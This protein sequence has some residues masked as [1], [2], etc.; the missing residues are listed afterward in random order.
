VFNGEPSHGS[1]VE[2]HLT[3]PCK[4]RKNPGNKYV[5]DRLQ[6]MEPHYVLCQALLPVLNH[7]FAVICIPVLN[8][9]VKEM[10]FRGPVSNYVS[11]VAAARRDVK[12]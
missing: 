11:S 5:Q 2:G 4:P 12:V 8:T 6:K 10:T 9:P 3:E 7:S 1:Q